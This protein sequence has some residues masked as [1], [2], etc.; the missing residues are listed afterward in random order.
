MAH[1][2]QSRHIQDSQGQ[3]MA[4]ASRYRSLKLVMVFMFCLEEIVANI[5]VS[6]AGAEASMPEEEVLSW[7]QTITHTHT[8]AH[9]HT[10]ISVS[11]AGAEASMP[12]EE[13]P[14]PGTRSMKYETRNIK[15][16]T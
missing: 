13:V 3:V 11:V 1:V 16:E 8:H 9:T 4:L 10:L 5:S 2:R 14:T 6:V 15:H 7:R 12:E